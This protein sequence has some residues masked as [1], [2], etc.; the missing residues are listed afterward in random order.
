MTEQIDRRSLLQTAGA[1]AAG[2]AL[3]G[4]APVASGHPGG[5]EDDEGDDEHGSRYVRGPGVVDVDRS[6]PIQV[7]VF[8]TQQL[9]DYAERQGR[10]GYHAAEV[11]KA[12][13]EGAFAQTDQFDVDVTIGEVT[14]IG[15]GRDDPMISGDDDP[16]V[17]APCPCHTSRLCNYGSKVRWVRDWY[18][19][20]WEGGH[21][22]TDH[23]GDHHARSIDANLVVGRGIGGGV[24]MGN[25]ARSCFSQAGD[26]LVEAEAEYQR[27]GYDHDGNNPQ[28]RAIRATIHEVGHT[29]MD[30][31]TIS[32]EDGDGDPW[33]PEHDMSEIIHDEETGNY[34]IT[35][36]GMFGD[37]N[38]EGTNEHDKSLADVSDHDEGDEPA[39]DGEGK[40]DGFAY[41]YSD[42]TLQHFYRKPPYDITWAAGSGGDG[43]AGAVEDGA[44]A[45]HT[46]PVRGDETQTLS[47]DLSG[48]D[49]ADLD[50][51]VTVDG[52]TPSPYRGGYDYFSIGPD[53][54]ET[55]VIE[56]GLE[57]GGEFGVAV[58]G[59]EGGGE[60][61]VTVGEHSE[62]LEPPTAAFTVEAPEQPDGQ[63]VF[64]A[65]ESS[66]PDGSIASHEW[67]FGDG[68][69]ATGAVVRHSYDTGGEHTVELVVTDGD[70]RTDA[71]SQS[72]TVDLPN[73]P[74]TA[75]A[76]AP[77]TAEVG[78]TV[79]FD[80]SASSDP[81]GSVADYRWTIA[82]EDH[83]GA[84]VRR[85]FE[86]ADTYTA[87]VRVEDDDGA[88]D[89]ATAT[90]TVRDGNEP[91]V[92]RIDGDES[93]EVGE[94][95]RFD[96]SGSR[97]PEDDV[98]T[99]G[100]SFDDGE[101]AF[102]ESV[103]H[104]YDEAGDYTVELTVYDTA[105]A[106]DSAT[107]EVTV[108]ED[109]SWWWPFDE[110]E[111]ESQNDDGGDEDDGW[112]DF[113]DDA[114]D[115]S[116]DS[117]DGSDIGGD[118]TGGSDDSTDDSGSDGS[119][120]G[121]DDGNDWT[122]GS[123]DSGSDDDWAVTGWEENYDQTGSYGGSGDTDS[124]DSDDGNDWTGGSDD[125]N[126]DS[127]G[128]VDTVTDAVT[129]T[130][131]TITSTVDSLW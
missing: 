42:A 127:G 37:Q 116:D 68:T 106:T 99:H 89:T 115:S 109:D 38:N 35:P 67:D 98:L 8:V 64:D 66:D 96:G 57:G 69:G 93:V 75:R 53:S 3:G 61:T 74:P 65:G 51:Y 121:S 71:A 90:V 46:Y 17:T 84:T 39:D 14:P 83:D 77:G 12:Y 70:G 55:I 48:P 113:G 45:T 124:D 28:F 76:D 114:D 60:Y 26:R 56:D 122:G 88:T 59:Y 85:R 30:S 80:A 22:T 126:D 118:W 95:A 117:D 131:D 27:F 119:D 110:E 18:W 125:S 111:E 58:H 33:G 20:E 73:R 82:G 44:V 102:G 129:D 11:T 97:D 91:P 87:T 16:P 100:W 13:L 23:C 25:P 41:F 101:A 54:E 32:D 47:I 79:E 128:V 40:P 7:T 1:L 72:V 2:G 31:G 43:F 19:N 15:P 63:Y 104:S 94:T 5:H 21:P 36:M 120:G 49:D 112:F 50:L 103:T 29:L 130:V 86:A 78:E 92:A 105:G 52:S 4:A 62:R 10:D 6:G 9:Y 24:S 81:D 34:A 123:D 108:E 107:L